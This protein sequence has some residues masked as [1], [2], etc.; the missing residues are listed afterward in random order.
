MFDKLLK[1]WAAGVG[2]SCLIQLAA[3]AVVIPLACLLVFVPLYLVQ[4][5]R[6]DE[7]SSFLVMVV[8]MAGFLVLVIGGSAAFGVWMVSARARG[9]DAAFTPLGLRGGM[10]FLNGRQYHGQI[11]GRAVDVYFYRGPTL[12]LY[13]AAKLGTRLGLGLQNRVGTALAGLL[14]RPALELTDPVLADYSVYAHYETWARALL[15]D[16]AAG[17]AL[18]RLLR[19][20]GGYELRQLHA[21]PDAWLLRL[22]HTYTDRITPDSVRGWLRDLE[23]L[24]RSAEALPPPAAA[25]E[26]SALERRLRSD[27][28]SFN[29]RVMLITC[30]VFAALGACLFG[31]LIAG[32]L[33]APGLLR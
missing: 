10:Y 20:L 14:K 28:G 33:I 8:P 3:A 27:R 15:R 23:F 12:D 26:P 7:T 19:D 29:N 30:A 22:Y 21:Q 5:T 2:R 32:L 24:A 11:A 13:L 17:P 1:Y 4:N 18:E 16:P 9:L 31:V 6:L 25:D